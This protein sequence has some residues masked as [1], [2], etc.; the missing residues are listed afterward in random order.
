MVA[1]VCTS[2]RE[3]TFQFLL[4]LLSQLVGWNISSQ[5]QSGQR[6]CHFLRYLVKHESSNALAKSAQQA[7]E[8]GKQLFR[9]AQHSRHTVIIS[10]EKRLVAIWILI[11]HEPWSFLCE[12]SRSNM[13][14][15][16]VAFTPSEQQGM[17]HLC[18]SSH[19]NYSFSQ[20]CQASG[21]KSKPMHHGIVSG[22]S[23]MVE[24]SGG[25]AGRL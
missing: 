11:S 25:H 18:Q 8:R 3:R 10:L 21:G 16:G 19:E 15:L 6:R 20:T 5:S 17:I 1:R 7:R 24:L 14:G 9:V 22:R 2:T 12:K 23:C 13:G 4:H